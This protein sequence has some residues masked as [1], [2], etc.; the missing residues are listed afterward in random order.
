VCVGQS[1]ES[2]GEELL[3]PLLCSIRWIMHWDVLLPADSTEEAQ[4]KSVQ[5]CEP[6]S[7]LVIA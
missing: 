5:V 1:L 7:C 2:A 4:D 6:S 3:V